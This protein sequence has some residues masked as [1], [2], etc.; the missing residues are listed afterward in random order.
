MS[1]RRR[2]E[3]ARVLSAAGCQEGA[4]TSV[5]IAVAATSRKRY[6]QAEWDDGE[7]FKNF[8]YD[9]MGVITGGP[10]YNVALPF[11][12]KDVPLED[13]LYHHLRCQLVHEGAMP[14]TIVFTQ[15]AFT[16]GRR[17][18]VLNLGTPLG[19]PSGWI[20]NIATAVWLARENDDLWTDETEKRSKAIQALE[21]RGFD[22]TYCRRPG[23]QTKMQKGKREKATWTHGNDSFSVS[24]PPNVTPI[25]LA[26]A[27]E[28]KARDLHRP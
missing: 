5:L 4:F 25:Q 6:Q 16:D 9:E 11:Q 12:G 14:E 7:A 20:E 24:Y 1:I 3:D 2:L 21:G 17:C 26:D 13:I 10:K 8:I 19:F 18:D 22:G 23:A 27:L 28:D 15:P